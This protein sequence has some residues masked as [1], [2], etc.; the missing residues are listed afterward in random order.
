MNDHEIIVYKDL[1][2]PHT[3][4]STGNAS[5]LLANRISWFYNLHGPSISMNTACSGSLVALHLACQSLRTGETQMGLVCGSS[6]IFAPETTV[7]LS[8]LNLLSPHGKCY[9]FDERANGYSRGE[10]IASLVIKPLSS[11]IRDGDN[12][13]ALIRGTGVNSDGRTPGIIK[14]S[15]DA[16]IAL[17]RDTYKRFGLDPSLTRYFEAHATGTQV[18]DPLE[19]KTIATVFDHEQRG[20]SPLFVGALKTNIGHL[21]G[22]SGIAGVIKTIL[23]LENSLIPPNIWLDKVNPA[24]KEEWDLTFPRRVVPF[25]TEEIRRASVNSFGFGGTNAHI[26]LDDAETFP[27]YQDFQGDWPL[28]PQNTSHQNNGLN[29]ALKLLTWSAADENG[30]TRLREAH[31][32]HFINSSYGET[33]DLEEEYLEK[34]AYTLI[35]CVCAAPIFHGEPFPS[36]ARPRTF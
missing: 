8:N 10:G 3:Y 34:L 6:L 23:V 12:I 1:E 16:Q 5:A 24:I 13:R 31:N 33:R 26:I 29:P 20:D 35:L 21:E 4:Q 17:I 14:P 18:G 2:M 36:A 25:P 19:A 15:S 22:A 11:A 32:T 30:V 7:G 27:N 9:S 28:Q